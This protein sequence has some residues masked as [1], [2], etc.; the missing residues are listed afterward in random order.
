[1]DF[2]GNWRLLH[3]TMKATYA[4]FLVSTHHNKS[5]GIVQIWATS[6]VNRPVAGVYTQAALVAN[7]CALTVDQDAFCSD[8]VMVLGIAFSMIAPEKGL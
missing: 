7:P 4:P 1:M 5:S 6:D 8:T 3:Y 2:G